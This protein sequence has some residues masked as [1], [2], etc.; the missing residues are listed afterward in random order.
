MSL[1]VGCGELGLACSHRIS[2]DSEE[3]LTSELRRHAADRHDVPQLNETLVAYALS[4]ARGG[5]ES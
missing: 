3:E 4:R 2:G 5:S 1:E